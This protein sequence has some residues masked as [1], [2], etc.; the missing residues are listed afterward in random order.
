VVALALQ[1]IEGVGGGGVHSEPSRLAPARGSGLV[2]AHSEGHQPVPSGWYLPR[3]PDKGT[4]VR[5]GADRTA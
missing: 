3:L 4:T 5:E 1:G 2:I